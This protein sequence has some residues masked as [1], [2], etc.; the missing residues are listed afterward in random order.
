MF[1]LKPSG[2]SFIYTKNN[3]DPRID[4]SGTP[5]LT[6]DLYDDCP[7]RTTLWYRLLKKEF[8]N[9]EYTSVYTLAL[10]VKL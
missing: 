7:L 4:P 5:A 3:K 1:E 9:P 10:H 6:C 2:K 8:T